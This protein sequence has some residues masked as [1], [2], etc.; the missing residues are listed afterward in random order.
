MEKVQVTVDAELRELI[1]GFLENRAKD[2][3][4]M[5]AAL[6][7]GDYDAL[8]RLGHS[9][10]GVGGGYGFHDITRMGAEIEQAAAVRDETT[11]RRL[12]ILLNEY[13]Q[14]V[15]VIYA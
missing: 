4:R 10:K 1:P 8:K 12:C 13:M 14:R 15:T 5:E 9:M 6:E 3:A 2:V 7:S 11:L